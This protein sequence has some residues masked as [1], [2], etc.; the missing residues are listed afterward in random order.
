[1]KDEDWKEFIKK[2]MDKSIDDIMA[3]IEADPKMKDVK[4]PEGMYEELMEKI[5]E[6]ER[7]TIY[8]QLSDEDKE[9]I[10]LGKVYKKKRR[11]DRFV[12]V[13][14]AMIVGLWLGTVCIGDEGDVLRFMKQILTGGEQSVS[15]TG[16]T[17]ITH[18]DE[19][20]ELY[21]AI[22]KE[23]GFTPVKLN[24]LPVG[25]SFKESSFSVDMQEINMYYV[26]NGKIH[27]IY[28]IRPNYRESSFVLINE[29]ERKQ[30]YTMVVRD[31]EVS[32]TEYNV[33][34]TGEKRWLLHWTHENV[35]YLLR[36]TNIEQT[37]VE[38]IVKELIFNI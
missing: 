28:T 38:K 7:Q 30:E 4:P 14:A 3:E 16:K 19:E 26:K 1:M 24:Y 11:F 23:Y 32:L 6:Y 2:E 12:V 5:H 21:E 20:E 31:V 25:T 13:L 27:I 10:Q 35:Q 18:Y 9:L 22:E 36:I 34:E 15:D 8:E 37:E 33:V 17:E 29:D